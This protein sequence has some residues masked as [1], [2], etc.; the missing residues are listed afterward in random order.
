M[1]WI[2]P[3]CV[4]YTSLSSSHWEAQSKE[5]V[6]NVPELSAGRGWELAHREDLILMFYKCIQGCHFSDC[7]CIHTISVL[8][9]ASYKIVQTYK[10]KQFYTNR[11]VMTVILTQLLQSIENN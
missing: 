9:L 4:C 11:T 10:W 5:I 2:P 6:R 1:W 8:Y 3:Q 7:S